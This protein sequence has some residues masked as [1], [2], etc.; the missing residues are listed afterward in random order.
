MFLF[1]LYPYFLIT[2]LLL[3][4]N[5]VNNISNI[6]HKSFI[7]YIIRLKNKFYIFYY[8]L[9]EKITFFLYEKYL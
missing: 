5:R 9:M 6:D 3:L 8:V 4:H 7:N 1:I 2:K